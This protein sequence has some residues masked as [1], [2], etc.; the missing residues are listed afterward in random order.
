VSTDTIRDAAR[1]LELTGRPVCVH[2]SLRSF[3]Q[4]IEGGA[5][6]VVDALLEE[7]CTLLV[8]TFSWR[9][10]IPPPDHLRFPRNGFDHSLIHAAGG[11]SDV[12]TMESREIDADMGAL[13][14]AV[15]ARSTHVRGDHPLN[16]FTAVG[17]MADDLIRDQSPLDVY[18]P[19]AALAASG[20]VVLLMGVGLDCMTLLH[21]AER[22]AGRALFRRWAL[23]P[24]GVPISVE[25]GGCSRGFPRLNGTVAPLGRDWVV[26]R[27]LWRAFPAG[28]MLEAAAEAISATPSITRCDDPTCVRC[29]DAILGG[30]LV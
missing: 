17:P 2:A 25:V 9:F 24:D 18:A 7:G 8:P 6:G 22:R 30:P 19:L 16:S 12:Y 20:G 14:A 11:A 1:T 3:G 29:R 13:P 21:L 28:R 5:N 10:S 15:L 26:G 27:S 4:V 23:G